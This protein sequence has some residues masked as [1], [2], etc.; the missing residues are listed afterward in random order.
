MNGGQDV[1]EPGSIGVVASVQQSVRFCKMR[2]F[3]GTEMRYLTV[4]TDAC[5]QQQRTG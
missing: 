4:N 1:L 3:D 5:D 2:L